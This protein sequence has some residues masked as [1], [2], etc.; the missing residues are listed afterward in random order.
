VVFRRKKMMK[1]WMGLN[2]IEGD[3]GAVKKKKK[4]S[5]LLEPGHLGS[6][7]NSDLNFSN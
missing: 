4:H 5:T 7:A 1:V 6:S 2:K 3:L